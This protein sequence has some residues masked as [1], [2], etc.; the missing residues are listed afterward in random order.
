MNVQD[1]PIKYKLCYEEELN[2][3]NNEIN[4]NTKLS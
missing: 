2:H 3:C 4:D 1:K